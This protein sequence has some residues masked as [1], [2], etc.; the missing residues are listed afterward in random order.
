MGSILVLSVK[1]TPQ[2]ISGSLVRII[3][4]IWGDGFGWQIT[5]GNDTLG[6]ELCF[7]TLFDLR[8]LCFIEESF[9][10]QDDFL[11]EGE[12]ATLNCWKE[13]IQSLIEINVNVSFAFLNRNK[14]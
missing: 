4:K 9:F 7:I 13:K 1:D 10:T 3:K 6:A 14:K 11:Q 2:I 8:K 12:G 5:I